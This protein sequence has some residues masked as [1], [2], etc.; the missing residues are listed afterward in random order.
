[1]DKLRIL[2]EESKIDFP[3]FGYYLPIVDKALRYE[4]ERPDTTIE[5]VNSL[6]QGFSKTIIIG[7]ENGVNED[8][9]DKPSEAKSD[10]LIKRAMKCLRENDD[11]YEDDFARRGASLALS[12]ATLRNARGDITHGKAVPKRL[13]S[14]R[15]LAASCNE[16]GGSLLRYMYASYQSIALER[17]TL[18]SAGTIEEADTGADGEFE[19][20]YDDN[21]DFNEFLDEQNPL[22]GKLLYS[23]ALFHLYLEEYVI[24]LESFLEEQ[25][26]ELDE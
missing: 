12:I 11:Q 7:L 25:E 3:E 21:P 23:E 4:T 14:H 9:L 10:K 17:R 24:L 22:D 1:M 19:V 18:E 2:I 26:E 16:L 15:N 6:L 5:C 13:N 20:N 8:E